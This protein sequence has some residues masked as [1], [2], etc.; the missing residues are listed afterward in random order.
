MI[1][2]KQ[3]TKPATG[4][5][6]SAPR[7]K[8]ALKKTAQK[9]SVSMQKTT[10]KTVRNKRATAMKAVVKKIRSTIATP[11]ERHRIIAEIAFLRAERRD[12]KGGD[13]V[14]DWLEAEQEVDSSLTD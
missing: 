4:K 11:G 13:P 14:D 9:K 3:I 7:K 6:K 2:A 8:S 12:F 10:G 5:K 1:D